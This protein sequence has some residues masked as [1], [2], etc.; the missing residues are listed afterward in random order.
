MDTPCVILLLRVGNSPLVE[1]QLYDPTRRTKKYKTATQTT[2][3]L[4]SFTK[5]GT[6]LIGL[7]KRVIRDVRA[8]TIHI[9]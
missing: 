9:E 8:T 4:H 2:V 6:I 1:N 7:F 3:R 5:W